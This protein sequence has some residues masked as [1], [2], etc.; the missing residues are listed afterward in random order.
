MTWKIRFKNSSRKQQK[1]KNIK[2]NLRDM[3]YRSKNINT[4]NI[5]LRKR[6]KNKWNKD[7][8]EEIMPK[9]LPKLKVDIK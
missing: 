2:E 7:I 5:N 3:K 8:L 9:N 6:E 4:Y 1:E